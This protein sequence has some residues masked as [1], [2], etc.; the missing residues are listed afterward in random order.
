MSWHDESMYRYEWSSIFYVADVA[1]DRLFIKTARFEKPITSIAAYALSLQGRNWFDS[2]KIW[3]LKTFSWSWIQVS[4]NHPL[5]PELMVNINSI[6]NR[7]GLTRDQIIEANQSGQLI[8]TIL[9]TL[10]KQKPLNERQEKFQEKVDKE[11]GSTLGRKDN[12]SET[13]CNFMNDNMGGRN[14]TIRNERNE[15]TLE[16]RAL[17]RCALLIAETAQPEENRAQ[18]IAE[19]VNDQYWLSFLSQETQRYLRDKALLFLEEL[20]D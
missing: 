19:K 5:D 13:I 12:I 1:S 2:L 10:D 14:L 7:I 3:F 17:D 20:Q 16:R 4:S 8:D 15:V 6:V 9:E 11:Y 18:W